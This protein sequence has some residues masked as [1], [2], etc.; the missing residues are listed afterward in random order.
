MHSDKKEVF[1]NR[2]KNISHNNLS[3]LLEVFVKAPNSPY[4]TTKTHSKDSGK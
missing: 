4:A 1:Q 3:D 2:K